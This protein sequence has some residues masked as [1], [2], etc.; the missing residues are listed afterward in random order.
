MALSTDVIVP[1]DHCIGVYFNT[2]SICVMP[3]EIKRTV[4]VASEQPQEFHFSVQTTCD[5]LMRLVRGLGLGRPL[6]LEGSPGVGKTS[7]VMAL[8][9]QCGVEV[10]RRRGHADAR[11]LIHF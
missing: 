5:N 6:L 9:E 8:A 11:S 7:L 2:H 1:A 3:Y 4:L 10:C